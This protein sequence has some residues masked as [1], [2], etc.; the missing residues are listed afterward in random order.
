MLLTVLLSVMIITNTSAFAEVLSET[1]VYNGIRYYINYQ[2]RWA[3]VIGYDG[4]AED[5]VI[6]SMISR[7]II[8]SE[9]EGA[10]FD[11]CSSIKVLEIPDTIMKIDET[12][13]LGMDNLKFVV[14]NTSGVNI[15]V[16]EDVKIVLKRSELESASE[17]PEETKAPDVPDITQESKSEAADVIDNIGVVDDGEVQKVPIEAEGTAAYIESS[18]QDSAAGHEDT[19]SKALGEAVKEKE[20]EKETAEAPSKED[21]ADVEKQPKAG[22]VMAAV[23]VTVVIAAGAAG[24]A[25]FYRR[26]RTHKED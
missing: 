11:G 22:N 15:V 5:L 23:A 25:I 26:K 18:T 16:K 24:A 2:E 14:S 21:T 4:N 7:G 10:A 13:F 20:T 3:S 9:I 19:E 17:S 1:E 12:A 6:P 8:V